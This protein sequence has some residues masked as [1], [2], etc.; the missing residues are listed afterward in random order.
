MDILYFRVVTMARACFNIRKILVL[1]VGK[2]TRTSFRRSK[3]E[4]S[5]RKENIIMLQTMLSGKMV[6]TVFG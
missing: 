4:R 5:V 3:R 6:T 2:M 1:Y